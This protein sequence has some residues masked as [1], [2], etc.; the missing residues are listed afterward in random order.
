M[1]RT[2]RGPALFE[3]ISKQSVGVH[4]QPRLGVPDWWRRRAGSERPDEDVAGAEATDLPVE[5][6]ER[7][8]RE[9][10]E[11][12]GTERGAAG[13]ARSGEPL[14]SLRDGQVRLV[15]NPVAGVVAVGAAL[16]IVAGGFAV[17]RSL[18]W[19]DAR[20]AALEA[21]DSVAA[22]RQAEPDSSVLLGV[23][24]GG[25]SSPRPGEASGAGQVGGGGELAVGKT[26]LVI[27][28]FAPSARADVV[29]AQ[30]F[31]ATKEVPTVLRQVS[32][33]YLL[34]ASEAFDWDNT[35]DRSK[36]E[37]FRRSVVALGQLYASDKYRGG[38]DFKDCYASRY[39]G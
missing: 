16:L 13:D 8:P 35:Q 17:G 19:R 12:R 27:Q 22:V 24:T 36:F 20:R 2:R 5:P 31:L 34:V 4:R 29:R 11:A 18:G 9:Y 37:S 33:G 6:E 38:Y 25:V 14:L 39:R 10:E 23:A 21:G 15:L 28:T 3:V 30:R 7:R 26:Y 32:N 1:V